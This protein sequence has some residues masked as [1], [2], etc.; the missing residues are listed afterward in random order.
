MDQNSQN[1]VWINNSRTVWPTEILM[2]FLSSLDYKMHVLFFKKLMII[3]RYS[4][5]HA[6]FWVEGEEPLKI[7]HNI[8]LIQD[9][10]YNLYPI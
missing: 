8:E 9:W 1:V 10:T 7:H 2:L 3:L 4:T 5:K 6:Y